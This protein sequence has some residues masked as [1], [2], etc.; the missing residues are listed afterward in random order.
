M[1]AFVVAGT[2]EGFVTGHVGQ[3]AVRIGIGAVAEL[4]FVVYLVSRGRAA[5]R[6]GL[7]GAIGEADELG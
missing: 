2:I 3:P 5:A 4:L 1:L 6:L 7:I